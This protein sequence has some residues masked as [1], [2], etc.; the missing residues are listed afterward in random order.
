MNDLYKSIECDIEECAF[1]W[2]VEYPAMFGENSND[3]IDKLA[4]FVK[5]QID[6]QV[7]ILKDE[8]KEED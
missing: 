6:N 2:F 8:L 3:L 5:N 4:T 7:N 1:K